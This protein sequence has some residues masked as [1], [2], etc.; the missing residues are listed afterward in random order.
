MSAKSSRR[1]SGPACTTRLQRSRRRWDGRSRDTISTTRSGRDEAQHRCDMVSSPLDHGSTTFMEVRMI[2]RTATVCFFIGIASFATGKGVPERDLPRISTPEALA[3]EMAKALVSGD[4]ERFTALAATREE[5][6]TLLET[7][8]AP[9][10]PEERQ[11]L[12]D[13]VAEIVGDRAGDFDRFQAMKKEAGFKEGAAVRFELMPLDRVYEKDGMKKIRHSRVRMFQAADGGK[14]QS[15]LISLDDR[16]LF[17][18]GWAF[19]SVSPGIG[20]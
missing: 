14:E 2:A 17:P 1:D 15:F 4:R 19:T 5:M 16:F 6:E 9:A 18:R 12:K 3:I 7:A 8:Q 13:K 20:K 10:R 11:E